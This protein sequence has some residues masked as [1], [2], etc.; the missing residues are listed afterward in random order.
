M[1]VA[2]LLHFAYL[3]EMVNVDVA[4]VDIVL[5]DESLYLT[6]DL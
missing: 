4:D 2:F 1:A 6:Y 5:L 3:N